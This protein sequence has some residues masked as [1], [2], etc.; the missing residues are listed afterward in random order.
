MGCH[1]QQRLQTTKCSVSAPCVTAIVGRKTDFLWRHINFSV[2]KNCTNKKSDILLLKNDTMM[3]FCYFHKVTNKIF[4]CLCYRCG[5]G[6]GGFVWAQHVEWKRINSII[7]KDYVHLGRGPPLSRCRWLWSLYSV[8][9]R[10]TAPLKR[11][12][13]S[14]AVAALAHGAAILWR[15][16]SVAH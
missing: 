5:A 12:L 1:T 8:S 11:L 14:S 3:R 13:C 9:R 16:S 2:L 15:G 4:F 10:H 7:T 6:R